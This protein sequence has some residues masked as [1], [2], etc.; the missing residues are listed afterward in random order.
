MEDL[1]CLRAMPFISILLMRF[2]ELQT[3]GKCSFFL[4]RRVLT[5]IV[6]SVDIEFLPCLFVG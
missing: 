5:A 6:A 1:S 2:L 3:I 4:F